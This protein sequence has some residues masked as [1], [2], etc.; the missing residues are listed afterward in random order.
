[1]ALKSFS[2]MSDAIRAG[3]AAGMVCKITISLDA[4]VDLT[5]RAMRLNN[6]EKA[7]VDLYLSVHRT[8]DRGDCS[9]G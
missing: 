5:R 4:G 3:Q 8:L 1:M 9:N 7:A 2:E 6:R